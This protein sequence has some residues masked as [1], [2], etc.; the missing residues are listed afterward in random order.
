M[1]TTL[2]LDDDVVTK[3]NAEMRRSGKSF[4]DTVNEFLRIGLNR[5][6][7][8]QGAD[9]FKVEARSLGVMPGLNYDKISEL[10]EE[11]EGPFHR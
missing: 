4:K 8:L 10:I 6:R 9:R 1:R 3:L 11:T 2:T 7:E 5:R